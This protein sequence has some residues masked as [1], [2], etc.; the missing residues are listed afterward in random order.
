MVFDPFCGLDLEDP[1]VRRQ[2]DGVVKCLHTIVADEGTTAVLVPQSAPVPF[3]DDF[4]RKCDLSWKFTA[5][6]RT[7]F[8]KT[9]H[10]PQSCSLQ[11]INNKCCSLKDVPEA[12]RMYVS[13]DESAQ[14]GPVG[15]ACA[16]VGKGKV[17]YVG[18]V[19]AEEESIQVVTQL[20]NL[21]G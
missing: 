14:P 1:N 2:V 13:T 5:Y 10:A 17:I 8:H 15:V 11:A 18:D 7:T 3:V 19:N 21:E 9:S 16:R 4:L 20:L 12:H 6:G